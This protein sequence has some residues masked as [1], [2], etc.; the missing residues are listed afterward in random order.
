MSAYVQVSTEAPNPNERTYG[1][2]HRG[3]GHTIGNIS[4][5]TS[6]TQHTTQPPSEDFTSLASMRTL[7]APDSSTN[8]VRLS[9][10]YESDRRLGRHKARTCL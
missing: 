1:F 5:F 7:S 3:W 8:E 6:Y 9:H 10:R 4:A 2:S